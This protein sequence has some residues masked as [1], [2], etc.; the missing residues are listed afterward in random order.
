MPKCLF[1]D[2]ELIEDDS[3]N[4]SLDEECGMTAAFHKE[5][6]CPNCEKEYEWDVC[7]DLEN[8]Y[9]TDLGEV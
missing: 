7:Y 9:I 6:H 8:P 3:R 2:E 1:C 4:T 5:G